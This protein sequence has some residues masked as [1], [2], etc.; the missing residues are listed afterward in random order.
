[1]ISVCKN[2]ITHQYGYLI[3]NQLP[4]TDE[5]F[6]DDRLMQLW[7]IMD[8]TFNVHFVCEEGCLLFYD[9]TLISFCM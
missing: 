8:L 4:L 3:Q 7:C 5:H 9:L 1:M 2:Q 6:I